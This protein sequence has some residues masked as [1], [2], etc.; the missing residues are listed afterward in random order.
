MGIVATSA[1]TMSG[2][3]ALA[4]ELVTW[5]ITTMGSYLD[6]ITEHPII[7]I[8]FIIMIAGLGVG[9]L[10]RIWHSVH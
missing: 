2:L 3:L 10:F 9:M 5:L 6:F 1:S 8:M 7:L 4:T